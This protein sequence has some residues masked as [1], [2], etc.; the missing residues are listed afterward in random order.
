MKNPRQ[1]SSVSLPRSRKSLLYRNFALSAFAVT[2]M[3]LRSMLPAHAKLLDDFNDNLKT[4]WTDTPNGG[5]V[6]ET[7]GAFTIITT[8]SAGALSSSK[9]TSDSFTVALG[10]TI[11]LRV[12]V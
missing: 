8:G 6:N 12:G 10:H 4:A 5:S 11:E 2:A 1:N 9:K 7:F 3:V